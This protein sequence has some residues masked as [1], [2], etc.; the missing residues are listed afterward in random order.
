M[1]IDGP[2]GRI[3]ALLEQADAERSA[4]V[5]IVCHPHPQ[6]GGSM[7]D[8]V[9]DA[10]SRALRANGIDALRFNFRGVGASEG[11]YDSGVGEIDDLLAVAAHARGEQGY[12]DVLVV[13]YSFGSR[14]AWGA[15]R[16]V[17]PTQL[18]LVAPPIGMMDY[19]AEHAPA[20]PVV[21]V[22]GSADD[23]A[24]GNAL[25]SW[26]A[27]RGADLR[28]IEGA[29]HFFAGAWDAVTAEILRTD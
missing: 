3:E 11:S 24:D 16:R 14:V 29:N 27:E 25:R 6:Y 8:A 7:H 17:A 28:L 13:G 5:G 19:P 12:D 2:A 26:C 20:C 21:V 1:I 10:A 23:F 15:A 22:I 18:V 9:V 4:R